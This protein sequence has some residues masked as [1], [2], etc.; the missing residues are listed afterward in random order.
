[1][2]GPAK[3]SPPPPPPPPARRPLA[4]AAAIDAAALPLVLA[5]AAL[6]LAPVRRAAAPPFPP[7]AGPDPARRAPSA[8]PAPP[9]PPTCYRGRCSA[10]SFDAAP[11]AA[12][13]IPGSH[14]TMTHAMARRRGGARLQCQNAPLDAQLAAGVRYLDVRA[15]V[16]GDE[17]RVYH[18]D[19][20]T[21][22]GLHHVLRS[23]FAFLDAHPSEAVVLRLK[24]EGPPLGANAS[25]SFERAWN[26]YRLDDPHTAPGAARHLFL[27][28]APRGHPRRRRDLA[29]PTLGALRSRVL[30]LQEFA[31]PDAGPYG[32]A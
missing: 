29:I 26:R 9:A 21:G 10:F 27:P 5:S 28:P 24:E 13:S 11:L 17:L 22:Y 12:L 2:G 25:L 30:L 20:D 15:R 19:G 3:A 31:A 16:L 32:L 14:D 23:V 8:S 1:M 4:R 18:A 7:A 6:L